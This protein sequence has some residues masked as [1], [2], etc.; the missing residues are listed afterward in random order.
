M[1]SVMLLL[2]ALCWSATF[3]VMLGTAMRVGPDVLR[4]V[5]RAPWMFVRALLAVWAG[6][7]LLTYAVVFLFDLG[8]LSSA[9]LLV[10]AFCPGIPL[11]LSTARN[12][13]GAVHTAFAVLLITALTEPL[14]IPLGSRL[15][16]TME[17]DARLVRSRDVLGVLVPTVYVP[18]V[19]GFF[20]RWSW[21]RAVPKLILAS[22]IVC[23]IG[24]AGSALLVFL[25]SLPLV[26][27]VPPRSIAAAFVL[28]W[29]DTALGYWAGWPSKQDQKALAFATALGNPALALVAI[30]A[31]YPGYPGVAMVATFLVVRAAALIPFELWLKRT[32]GGSFGGSFDSRARVR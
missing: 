24:I 26:L 23:V 28:T 17:P 10:M 20:A 18:V 29:A 32:R 19:L 8:P 9:T 1:T 2:K 15:L 5:R 4:D 27:Q 6:V 12:V 16:H 22:D 14:L 13:R 3:S 31:V 25:Q 11:L 30:E 7:P 21:P